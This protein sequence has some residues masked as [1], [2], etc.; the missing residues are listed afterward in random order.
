MPGVS[1]SSAS[2]RTRFYG[3]PPGP[4]ASPLQR[5]LHVRR[6]L[7]RFLLAALPLY[8]A[9]ALAVATSTAWAALGL[10]TLLQVLTIAFLSRELRRLRR[11]RETTF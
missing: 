11:E 6:I 4:D 9:V 5:V 1:R 2:L 3:E 10:V 7:V 8:L